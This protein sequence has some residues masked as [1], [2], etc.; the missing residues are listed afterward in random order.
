MKIKQKSF[1][2]SKAINV[3]YLLK[4]PLVRRIEG[5]AVI[6]GSKRGL[7]YSELP[8]DRQGRYRVE[9]NGGAVGMVNSVMTSLGGKVASEAK[10]IDVIS[11]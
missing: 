4:D 1:S 9:Q 3:Y 11:R 5:S 7:L 10:R 2:I 8:R 6:R